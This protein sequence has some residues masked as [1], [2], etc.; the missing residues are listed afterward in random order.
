[1]ASSK[2]KLSKCE[3]SIY[4]TL[5]YFAIF[6]Y[7][8][9]L[10]RLSTFL[11]AD[12]PYT[13]TQLQT[14]IR[15]LIQAKLITEHKGLFSI[16]G[17]KKVDSVARGMLSMQA[18]KQV[19]AVA[20]VISR[21]P[22]I[23]LLGITGSCA[24]FNKEESGDIDVFIVTK[25]HRVWLTRFFL[26]VLLKILHLYRTDASYVSKICPNLIVAEDS[27]AWD[28]DK[29]V[30]VAHEIC[31]MHPILDRDETYFKFLTQNAWIRSYF[32][33]FM[34]TSL[35]MVSPMYQASCVDYIELLS[36]K[37]QI[38]Y[39]RRHLT[40]EVVTKSFIHF[41]KTDTKEQVLNKF[42]SS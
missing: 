9:S 28:H 24:A 35:D 41:N 15:A 10:Y 21:I 3:K 29:N 1:M 8:V 25:R 16:R 7:P 20:P 42:H 39:M 27:M 12:E 34:H 19:Q 23:R 17:S 6:N 36:M 32:P 31:A 5:S 4:K 26:V 11:I 2:H 40:K 33:H 22:W 18:I 38:F 14:S 30:F 37:L 13:L